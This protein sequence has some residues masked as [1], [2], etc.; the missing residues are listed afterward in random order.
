MQHGRAR[1]LIVVAYILHPVPLFVTNGIDL[2]QN[3]AQ[4]ARAESIHRRANFED[5]L[6][7]ELCTLY[8]HARQARV[9]AGD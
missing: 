7:V 1:T 4:S 2:K 9:T 3:K 6:L 5:V 8:L